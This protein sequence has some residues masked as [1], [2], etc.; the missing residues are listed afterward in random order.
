MARIALVDD[1]PMVVELMRHVM[2]L[3]RHA[4]T[5][6]QDSRQALTEITDPAQPLPW[7]I[8]LDVMMPGLDGRGFHQAL[9][10]DARTKGVPLVIV[11]AH[12]R[13]KREFE[14]SPNVRA[15][16]E[17]PFEVFEFRRQIS[18]ILGERR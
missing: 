3:D 16:I 13:F 17:K 1:D 12:A 15:V 4:L 5:V 2:E 6:Y 7:L 9:Q 14:G 8:I 10:A 11:T 18:E